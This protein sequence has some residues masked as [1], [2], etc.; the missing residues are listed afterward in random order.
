MMSPAVALADGPAS[1]SALVK[2]LLPAVVNISTTQ[3]IGTNGLPY[4]EPPE[5]SPL[6]DLLDEVN[7]NSGQGQD[8]LREARSLGSGFLVSADG[9]LVTNNHVIEGADE[10]LVYTHD[11]ER[12]P[13]TLVGSDDKT[14]IAV[15]KVDAGKPLPYV[16]F[17]DSDNAEI[18][19]WLVVIGNPFGLGG[20]VSI[21]IVSARNRNINSGPYDDFIQTD[22]AINQGSSGGP[23]FDMNGKVVGI[24]SAL[25]AQGGNSLGIGF[26]IPTNLAKKVVSQLT[27]FGHTKR[28]WLGVGIQEVNEDVA[29]AVGLSKPEGA[30]VVEVTPAGPAQNVLQEGDVIL[31][32]NGIPI[33]EVN[34]LPINVSQTPVGTDVTVEVL[35]DG[36]VGDMHITLGQLELGEKLISEA[37]IAQASAPQP[38]VIPEDDGV[39]LSK[40]ISDFAGFRVLPITADIRKGLSLQAHVSGLLL[41]YVDPKSDAAKKGMRE[42]LVIARFDGADLTSVGQL[43][44]LIQAARD[45][46]RSSVLVKVFDPIGIG[47]YLAV[48][49]N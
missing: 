39:R 36:E 3:Y 1:V 29:A 23:V 12:Y 10:I 49:L 16:E 21:G 18:G 2:N 22:A 44:D 17:G 9:Y 20:S 38:D 43:E 15:L 30:L 11:N 46:K 28:G 6:G 37:R 48:R 42:G 41:G 4:P 24:A 33:E 35:R 26:A 27:E 5:G 8:A 31:T 40:E 34:D 45:H 19:D 25:V 13:A 7:P 32:Y 47:R 14:D